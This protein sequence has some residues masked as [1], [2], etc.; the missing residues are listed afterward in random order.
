MKELY[1]PDGEMELLLLRSVL[2]D[3]GIPYFVRND[4]FGGL[5]PSLYAEAYNRRQIY[6]PEVHYEEAA[7]LVREFLSRTG[8]D[9]SAAQRGAAD[10]PLERWLHRVLHW[11]AG[12]T[13]GAE[14]TSRP[15]F[16]LIR[17]D[18]PLPPQADE[19]DDRRPPLR[20]VR[21]DRAGP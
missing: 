4:T 21:R 7:V 1:S 2:D 6:V 14:P 19:A 3:A 13:G 15:P 17:N 12:L 9:A 8:S 11:W 10:G 18:R 16:R 20:L 5:Y